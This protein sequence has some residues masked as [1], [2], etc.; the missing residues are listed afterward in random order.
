MVPSQISCKDQESSWIGRQKTKCHGITGPDFNNKFVAIERELNKI[1]SFQIFFKVM[2]FTW[3]DGQNRPLT[4]DAQISSLGT[5]MMNGVHRM[6]MSNRMSGIIDKDR[7]FIPTV[8]RRWENSK[9]SHDVSRNY[10]NDYVQI[11]IM[12]FLPISQ[13]Q[14][15]LNKIE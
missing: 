6:D 5:S 7:P 3:S 4:S 10:K 12:R 9:Y 1:A 8:Y 2:T 14:V 13:L 11:E 15:R